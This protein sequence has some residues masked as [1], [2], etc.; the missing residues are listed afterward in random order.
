ML[1]GT[2]WSM[3]G[4]EL[5]A[6]SPEEHRLSILLAVERDLASGYDA[7]I[8]AWAHHLSRAPLKFVITPGDA[9]RHVDQV[10]A[11]ETATRRFHLLT[12]SQFGRM[13]EVWNFRASQPSP[14]STKEL[15]KLYTDIRQYAR[16]QRTSQ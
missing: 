10:A 12:R 9:D 8:K 16:K 3:W 6:T 14:P 2:P 5:V 7:I 15:A 11:R 13:L 1:T 4:G